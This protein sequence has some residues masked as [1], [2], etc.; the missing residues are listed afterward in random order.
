MTTEVAVMSVYMLAA[1]K[2]LLQAKCLS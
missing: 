2:H 1:D